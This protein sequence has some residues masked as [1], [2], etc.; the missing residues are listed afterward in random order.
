MSDNYSFSKKFIEGEAA[1]GF[2][3]MAYYGIVTLNSFIILHF[4]E[5]YE[6]GLY[7][8]ILVVIAAAESLVIGFLDDLVL[9]D[10]SRYLGRQEK[11]LA[12]RIFNEYAFMRIFLAVL[13]T[14]VLILGAEVVSHY[15]RQDIALF[16]RIASLALIFRVGLSVM[17]LFFNGS[18]Y[19]S[20]FGASVFGE[21]I[22]FGVILGLWQWYGLGIS[23]III[24]YVVGHAAA[25]IFS[26]FHFWS[27]YRNIFKGIKAAQESLVKAMIRLYGPWMGLRYVL[28]RVTNNLRPWVMRIFVSTEAVGLFSFAQSLFA[29]IAR[30]M[31]LG[32]LGNLMPRELDNKPRLKY[33]FGTM[34][35]YSVFLSLA[36]AVVSLTAVPLLVGLIFPKYL[37]AMPLFRI[38]TAIIFLY[39]FYKVFR[40]TLVVFKEQKVLVLRSLDGSV[41]SPLILVVLL[42]ILGVKGA[43]IEW[44]VTYLVTTI[45]FYYYLVKAHPCL[46]LRLKNFYLNKNDSKIIRQ[47]FILARQQIKNRLSFF[48]KR[49]RD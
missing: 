25:F 15:Y 4:L 8:L 42:P 46:Q 29:V 12:K 17:N 9:T 5:V 45:L 6:Y 30:L 48:D 37:P 26:G 19:F 18:L 40:M 44:V 49:F 14:A 43:A 2:W 31:P 41:L 21:I 34:V 47:L 20:A 16:L 32:M 23:Q 13:G 38:M 10:L 39:G 7:Q 24:A 27:W 33:I 36:G 3:N 35:K 11:S 28:S 22:K 1:S